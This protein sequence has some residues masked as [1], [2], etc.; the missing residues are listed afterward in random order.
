MLAVWTGGGT[1]PAFGANRKN[2]RIMMMIPWP[3]PKY[4]NVLWKP[5]SLIIAWI[6]ATV[7]A[8]PAPNPAAVMP[9]ARPRLSGNHF[10]A[11]PTQVQRTPPARTTRRGPYLST[12]QPSTGT[13]QVSNSTNRVN[14]H[15]IDARSH[16][17]VFWI[18]G[19]KN[20]Q[21]Y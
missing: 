7:R 10:S 16:P 12:N 13:S 5:E 6:G 11:L 19:T 14:A 15:W 20:V 8:E 21:P 4:R 2:D 17:N 9:A 3:S 18:S 1:C